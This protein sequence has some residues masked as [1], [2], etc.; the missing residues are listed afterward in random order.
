MAAQSVSPPP[1]PSAEV[2]GNA[3]VDQY[4]HILHHSPELVF[5]FYH[6]TSLLSRPEPDGHMT[7]VTTMKVSMTI[8]QNTY[9]SLK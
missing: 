5:R 9:L 7:T 2:I 3:F 6:D 1:T 4:Y 8:L